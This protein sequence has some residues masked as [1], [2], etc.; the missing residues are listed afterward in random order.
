MLM[1]TGVYLLLA[2]KSMSG[3]SQHNNGIEKGIFLTNICITLQ[4]G[5][6][7]CEFNFIGASSYALEA[8]FYD[9]TILEPA[10][11]L[12]SHTNTLRP[13]LWSA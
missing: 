8:D 9:I 1:S 10:L 13:A 2:R 4:L 7:F 11:W 6:G 12:H 5:L 3:Q